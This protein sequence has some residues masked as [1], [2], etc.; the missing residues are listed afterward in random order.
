[1]E[2]TFTQFEGNIGTILGIHGG[3]ADVSSSTFS[4]NICNKYFNII[5]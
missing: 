4:N 1:M 2:C 3:D 5:C